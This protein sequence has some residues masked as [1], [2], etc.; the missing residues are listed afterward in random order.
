MQDL[1]KNW[2][3]SGAAGLLWMHRES[4]KQRGGGGLYERLTN[5]GARREGV[6]ELGTGWVIVQ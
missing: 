5:K 3:C 1:A 4:H 2:L 6:G